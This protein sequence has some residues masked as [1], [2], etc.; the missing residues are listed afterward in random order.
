MLKGRLDALDEGLRALS[1]KYDQIIAER[2]SYH[3]MVDRLCGYCE[4]LEHRIKLQDDYIQ[5]LEDRIVE[6]EAFMDN[7]KNK[8]EIDES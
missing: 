5:K 6:L 7:V 3:G 4:G 8:E 2:K 1:L